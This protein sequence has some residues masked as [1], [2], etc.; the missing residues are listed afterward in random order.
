[1]EET[2]MLKLD[3]NALV[4]KSNPL[5][6]G[7]F[8]KGLTPREMD[9]LTV[10]F[11]TI[12]YKAT[13]LSTVRISIKD[14]IRLYGLNES[15]SAYE[16]VAEVSERLLSRVVKVK[17]KKSKT[18]TQYQILSRAKYFMGEGVAEFRFHDELKPYLLDISE[19][20]KHVLKPFLA[21]HSGYAKRIYELLIQYRNMASGSDRTWS[22][23]ISMTDLREY[24]SIEKDDYQK[25]SH[26]KS[27][28]LDISRDQINERTDISFEYEEI[29]MG[30]R[31]DSIR[32]IVSE[33]TKPV[34]T[35]LIID[36][37]GVRV[38]S[39][40]LSRLI[41]HGV[42]ESVATRLVANHSPEVI[43]YNIT[44]LER[45][46]KA[47]RGKK[48]ENPAG[49]LVEAIESDRG[50]QQT[51]FDQQQ[52]AEKKATAEAARKK[53]ERISEL[54]PIVTKIRKGYGAHV[55]NAICSV[56][57]SMTKNDRI[58]IEMAFYEY[59]KN[60]KGAKIFVSRFDGGDGKA[61]FADP[62]VRQ[63]GI[64]YLSDHCP[65]F[66]IFDK[67]AFAKRHGV[68]NFEELEKEYD[69]L[70]K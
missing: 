28:V 70:T 21:I 2:I 64:K 44:Q 26:F 8:P 49:W 20:A 57:D 58:T 53:K 1:M 29:R 16:S 51:I 30:R 56:I 35:S 14:L 10:L 42:N 23:T 38:D 40:H 31:V 36:E 47:K 50:E 68:E 19:Y 43:A 32:F 7:R 15:N 63:Y 5:L 33:N 41:I 65:D 55:N 66:M 61:W 52:E 18:L 46:L 34:R 62:M 4:V 24:L 27:R 60:Q 9:L 54:E 3:E 12:D 48:I 59:M 37:N 17:D 13:D 67:T 22:R 45:N 25:Q 69:E 39:P 6:E 11:T